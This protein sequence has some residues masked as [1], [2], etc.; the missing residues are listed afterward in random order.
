[1]QNYVYPVKKVY[2]CCR[3]RSGREFSFQLVPGTYRNCPII[4]RENTIT[5][6][7]RS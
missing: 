4:V 5:F 3:I 1:M 6:I 7:S 2:V